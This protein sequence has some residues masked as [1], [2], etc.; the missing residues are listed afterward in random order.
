MMFVAILAHMFGIQTG[1][2]RSASP[3]LLHGIY[4]NAGA[5]KDA[6]GQ[7]VI[8]EPRYAEGTPWHR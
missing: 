5:T 8:R 6:S 7:R 3:A 1:V 4:E 2:I